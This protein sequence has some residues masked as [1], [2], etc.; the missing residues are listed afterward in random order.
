M[1]PYNLAFNPEV[2]D[3]FREVSTDMTV[4]LDRLG[5]DDSKLYEETAL[6]AADILHDDPEL[7]G[8][9]AVQLAVKTLKERSCR[10]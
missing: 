8:Y 3:H 1:D 4:A 7:S 5:I 6:L 2:R 9:E 10:K